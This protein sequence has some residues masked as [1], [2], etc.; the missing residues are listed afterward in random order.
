MLKERRQNWTARDRERVT[1]YEHQWLGR[2]R[3]GDVQEPLPGKHSK[4]L[5]DSPD[6]SP[7]K[8]PDE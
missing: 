6:G 4:P 3:P 1:A 2:L 8:H 5:R 7:S